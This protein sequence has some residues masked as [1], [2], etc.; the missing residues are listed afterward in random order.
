MALTA[1]ILHARYRPWPEAGENVILDLV[2]AED[3]AG[4]RAL[5]WWYL[6]LPGLAAETGVLGASGAWRFW[7]SEPGRLGGSRGLLP[8]WPDEDP[9]EP[10]L[11]IGELHHP[12]EGREIRK[13]SWLVLDERGLYTGLAIFGAIGIGSPE[14]DD[15]DVRRG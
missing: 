5:F 2:A 12:T 13:P 4:Y 15:P 6:A 3:P 11:V 8:S 1:V 9:R 14:S 10:G 7:I